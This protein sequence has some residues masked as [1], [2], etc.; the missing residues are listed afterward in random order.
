MGDIYV[1][2]CDIASFIFYYATCHMPHATTPT[3]Y[4]TLP[5]SLGVWVVVKLNSR[6]NSCLLCREK[7]ETCSY[8]KYIIFIHSKI[9]KSKCFL[10]LWY[11][12]LSHALVSPMLQNARRSSVSKIYF[13]TNYIL[14]RTT[15]REFCRTMRTQF[16][17]SP[18]F[19][20]R[21]TEEL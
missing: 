14:L 19:S 21:F 12:T 20:S 4:G 8:P 17:I 10:Q 16:V 2:L 7:S 1:L 9:L 13:F 5:L 3:V 11:I 18:L 6:T 15:K